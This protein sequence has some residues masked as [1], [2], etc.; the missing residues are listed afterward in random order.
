MSPVRRVR[1]LGL[2]VLSL[3]AAVSLEGCGRKGALEGPPGTHLPRDTRSKPATGTV[4]EAPAAQATPQGVAVPP[5]QP[6]FLD[7]LIK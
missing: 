3:T 4:P 5:Q 7:P 2:V 6:F 1:A